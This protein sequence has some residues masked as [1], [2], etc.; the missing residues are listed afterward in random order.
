VQELVRVLGLQIRV[1]DAR[2]IREIDVAF[3]NLLHERSDVLFVGADAFFVGADAFFGGR[4]VQLVTLATPDRI[5]RP[6]V[7]AISLQPEG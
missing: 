4:H 6:M 1:L 2:T 5:R 7:R 3:A